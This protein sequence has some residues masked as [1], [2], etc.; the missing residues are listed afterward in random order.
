MIGTETSVSPDTLMIAAMDC[1]FIAGSGS[2]T[3]GPG[4][5][6][7]GSLAGAGKGP[8]IPE[9]AVADV[10]YNTA[11]SVSIWQTPDPFGA[12]LTRTDRYVEHFIQDAPCLPP[13]VRHPAADGYSVPK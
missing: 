2:R 4:S 5:F 12:G 1:S 13:S 8:E 7:N 3:Y 11:Y 9:P 10:N 6:Y